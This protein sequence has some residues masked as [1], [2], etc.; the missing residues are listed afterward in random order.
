MIWA[1]EWRF[2]SS[3]SFFGIH[4]FYVS[5]TRKW[6]AASYWKRESKT[7]MPTTVAM[8]PVN[9]MSS[10]NKIKLGRLFE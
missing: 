8:V 9:A 2:V 1:S 5:F 7:A 6:N 10:V 3:F 4:V